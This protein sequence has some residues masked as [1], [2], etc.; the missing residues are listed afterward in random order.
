MSDFRYT[1]GISFPSAL[2]LTSGTGL[3]N[4]TALESKSGMNLKWPSCAR[5]KDLKTRPPLVSIPS[6][7]HLETH[8]NFLE[9]GILLTISLKSM[10]IRITF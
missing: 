2:T 5:L 7:P 8:L 4:A 3:P 10:F 9:D 1:F 6:S